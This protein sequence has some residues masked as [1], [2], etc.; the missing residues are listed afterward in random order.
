MESLSESTRSYPERHAGFTEKGYHVYDLNLD[1]DKEEMVGLNKKAEEYETFPIFN[2]EIDTTGKTVKIQNDDKRRTSKPIDQND[3]EIKELITIM[4][5]YVTSI[6]PE[7]KVQKCVVL[8]SSKGCARQA[9]HTDGTDTKTKFC[10]SVLSIQEGTTIMMNGRLIDLKVGHAIFFHS[11]VVHNGSEYLDKKNNRFFFYIGKSKND[12]PINSVGDLSPKYCNKCDELLY[13]QSNSNPSDVDIQ[14]WKRV[15]YN[16]N[17]RHCK[18]NKKNE[19][20]IEQQRQ[21]AALLS[22]KDRERMK[23]K[24]NKNK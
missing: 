21:K 19:K 15:R 3:P 7:Y 8:S 22:K 23:I 10:S 20:E 14:K 6:N 16:H 18:K 13:Y 17:D 11:D 9:E 4:N 5:D 24:D 12:I 2:E 1:I